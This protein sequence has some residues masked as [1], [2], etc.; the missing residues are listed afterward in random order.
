LAGEILSGIM[1]IIKPK[2]E[3]VTAKRLGKVVIGTVERD[4]HDIGKNVV[5]FMLDAN[6]FDVY[7]L[8]VDVPSQKF[9]EK[10]REVK[11]KVVGLSGLLTVAY[12]SMKGTVEAIKEAG[13]REKV[14]IMIGGGQVNKDIAKYVGADAY[15]K[16]AVE[17]V[18]L[19]K[20]W[21]DK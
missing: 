1:E 11:P 14:K 19:C 16:D 10:I 6:G 8:G 7:D 4:I 21:V 17:A 5:T 9:V 2:L 13:L 20:R 15:G 12:D 18:S 3:K